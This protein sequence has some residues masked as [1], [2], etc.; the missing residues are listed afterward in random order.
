MHWILLWK[1]PKEM[2]ASSASE[3][4]IRSLISFLDNRGVSQ[5]VLGLSL[6]AGLIAAA[7]VLC[8]LSIGKLVA[9]QGEGESRKTRE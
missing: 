6:I 3:A 7:V 8:V 4:S 5:F 1:N 9:Q 2:L